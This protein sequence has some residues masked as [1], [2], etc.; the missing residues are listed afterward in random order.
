MLPAQLRRSVWRAALTATMVIAGCSATQPGATTPPD[1][2]GGNQGG[3]QGGGAGGDLCSILT[4]DE[5]AELAGGDV[6]NSESSAGDCNFTVNEYE[7][8]NVRYESQFDPNLET[9]HLICDDGEE[10]SGVGDRALWC[11]SVNVLYFN[12]GDRTLAVQLVFITTDPAR[13]QKD[14]A[15]DIARRIAEG[16]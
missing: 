5:V 15:S 6:T 16:L 11:P 8:I 3:N 4:E 13:D 14:I 1:G 9:A 7:L 10:V 2:G 12:K